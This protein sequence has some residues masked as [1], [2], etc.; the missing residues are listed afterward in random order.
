MGSKIVFTLF[1]IS[2]AANISFGGLYAIAKLSETRT[3]SDQIQRK[4]VSPKEGL[5]IMDELD[6]RPA[7]REKLAGLRKDIWSKRTEYFAEMQFL[8]RSIG[9]FM[10]DVDEQPSERDYENIRKLLSKMAERQMSFREK[11]IDHLLDVK[12]MLDEKQKAHFGE[13]LKTRIFRG[14]EH[15]PGGRGRRSKIQRIGKPQAIK[16]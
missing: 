12:R 4:E 2:L 6:L 11:V 5:C 15:E 3:T 8:R 9:E 16:D 14:M 10:A 7:Q 13:I 1:C